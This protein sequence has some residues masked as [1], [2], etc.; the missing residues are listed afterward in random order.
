MAPESARWGRGVRIFSDLPQKL[1][2]KFKNLFTWGRIAEIA[3][4][5]YW[6][7]VGFWTVC[8]YLFGRTSVMTGSLARQII[9]LV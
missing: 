1:C 7:H 4:S 6:Q 8:S 2:Y 3:S 9:K 5:T